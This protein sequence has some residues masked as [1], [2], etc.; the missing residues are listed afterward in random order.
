MKLLFHLTT[1]DE[2]HMTFTKTRPTAGKLDGIAYASLDERGRAVVARIAVFAAAAS[3]APA[4][5]R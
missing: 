1:P 5:P 2:K 3:G 4:S